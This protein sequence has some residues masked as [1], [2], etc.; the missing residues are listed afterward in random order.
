M[1]ETNE[2]KKSYKV[3]TFIFLIKPKKFQKFFLSSIDFY[4]NALSMNYK[5]F[6]EV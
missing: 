5:S 4:V 1:F 6:Y 3:L 2:N